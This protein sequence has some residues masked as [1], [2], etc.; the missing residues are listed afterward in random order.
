MWKYIL[1]CLI[2][3]TVYRQSIKLGFEKILTDL[4]SDLKVLESD[5]PQTILVL[6]KLNS[7]E[8]VPSRENVEK[9]IA[10]LKKHSLSDNSELRVIVKSEEIN[11]S[12]IEQNEL[13]RNTLLQYEIRL[14]NGAL[15]SMLIEQNEL[16]L[17]AIQDLQGLI[18]S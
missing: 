16:I 15:K 14:E 18:G 12:L 8:K 9:I 11:S 10:L 1:I 13:W 5:L 3:A 6:D 2:T 4:I 17:K 7:V